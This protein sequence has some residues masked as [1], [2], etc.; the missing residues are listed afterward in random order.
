MTPRSRSEG[1]FNEFCP[2]TA[3]D[4]CAGSSSLTGPENLPLSRSASAVALLLSPSDGMNALS[5]LHDDDDND[6]FAIPNP[7][8]EGGASPHLE[9]TA[10][11]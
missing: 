7:S 4:V 10:L 2:S 8:S 9:A 1:S 5:N 6:R 11:R 3:P